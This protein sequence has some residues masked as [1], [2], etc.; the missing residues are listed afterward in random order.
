MVDETRVTRLRE[1]VKAAEEGRAAEAV[2]LL[3]GTIDRDAD[4]RLWILLGDLYRELEQYSNALEVFETALELGANSAAVY[5]GIGRVY[6][7]LGKLSKAEDALRKSVALGPTAARWVLLG[8]VQSSLGED[9]EAKRSFLNA[10]E[11]EPQDDEAIFGLAMLLRSVDPGEARGLLERIVSIHP[12]CAHA[13]RELG[14]LAL[15]AGNLDRADEALSNASRLNST[16]PW[17]QV[18]IA[19]LRSAQGDPRAAEACLQAAK[20]NAI[21]EGYPRYLLGELYAELGR[22]SLAEEQFVEAVGLEPNDAET[23]FRYSR[24]LAESGR[25][26]E[27]RSCLDRVL[28]LD[29]DHEGAKRLYN[30]LHFG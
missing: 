8:D 5:S 29:E 2:E 18:Y 10:L 9:D 12:D 6:H 27:A 25:K 24:F 26:A 19:K 3:Q 15:K 4:Q 21:L 11:L 14:W 17:T 13:F 1:A 22:W 7:E 16:D 30:S 28:E 20:E 23:L